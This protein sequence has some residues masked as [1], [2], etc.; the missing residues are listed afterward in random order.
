MHFSIFLIG[1]LLPQI[2]FRKQSNN[3][4]FNLLVTKG[5]RLY[6]SVVCYNEVPLGHSHARFP[7]VH[8]TPTWIWHVT[9]Y[10]GRD[11]LVLKFVNQNLPVNSVYVSPYVVTRPPDF[12]VGMAIPSMRNKII[13]YR[14]YC[15]FWQL[16]VH[17]RFQ[18]YPTYLLRKQTVL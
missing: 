9:A 7:S 5:K 8:H 6:M 1:L 14:L 2:L 17:L 4:V 16:L 10:S 12:F 3:G 15:Q 13:R 18:H 11:H